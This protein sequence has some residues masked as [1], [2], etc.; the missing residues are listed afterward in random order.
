MQEVLMKIWKASKN[1]IYAFA[2][3]FISV[4]LLLTLAFAIP[5][6]PVQNNVK[7][8]MET[9][10]TKQKDHFVYK[11]IM[12]DTGSDIT[13]LNMI[14][15]ADSKHPFKSAMELQKYPGG[16]EGFDSFASD[17]KDVVLTNREVRFESYARYWFGGAIFLR[18]LIAMMPMEGVRTI[19]HIIFYALAAAIL[20]LLARR[21]NIF[22]SIA[23][24]IAMIA[25]GFWAIPMCMQYFCIYAI[26][27]I[28]LVYLLTIAKKEHYPLA[29]FIT[30]MISTFDVYSAPIVSVAYLLPAAFAL[31]SK[32][33]KQSIKQN[34]LMLIKWA[35]LWAI[36][37]ILFWASKWVLADMT[38][39]L[40]II[41]DALGKVKDW[42]TS[43]S[44]DGGLAIR[45]EIIYKNFDRLPKNSLKYF[46][47]TIIAMAAISFKDYKN[48]I[49]NSIYFVA[50]ALVPVVWIFLTTKHAMYHMYFTYRN[51]TGGLFALMLIFAHVNLK[52]IFSKNQEKVRKS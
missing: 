23:F 1:Y 39:D 11:D 9:T 21:L 28:A 43:G 4:P 44:S 30:G 12:L 29:F 38:T 7:K 25:S 5:N 42:T 24:A 34:I 31:Y 48:W 10:F 15:F 13:F 2:I 3:M 17:F 27:M 49:K 19:M 52:H 51:L 40:N 41:K 18:P 8:S 6:K 14:Y 50:I 33:S 20:F 26:M 47:L 36:G 32:D 35:S 37:F 16:G 45:F 46:A 22:A